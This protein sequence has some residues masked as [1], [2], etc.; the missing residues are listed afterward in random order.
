MTHLTIETVECPACGH[1]HQIEVDTEKAMK[2][3]K[4]KFERQHKDCKYD[5]LRTNQGEGY[6]PY[7]RTKRR[8]VNG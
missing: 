5:I 1:T 3:A 8:A 2:E 4:E 7:G 6:E